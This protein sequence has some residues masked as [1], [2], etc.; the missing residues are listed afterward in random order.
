MLIH[1]YPCFS[2]DAGRGEEE[3]WGGGGVLSGGVISNF[4]WVG[5]HRDQDPELELL[6]LPKEW[7]PE[8]LGHLSGNHQKLS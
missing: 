5:H 2:P 6:S 8:G 3:G 1:S 7:V 4:H